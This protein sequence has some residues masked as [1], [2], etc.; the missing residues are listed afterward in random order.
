MTLTSERPRHLAQFAG[1]FLA[2]R[3]DLDHLTIVRRRRQAT[4]EQGFHP[5]GLG[6][7]R[8][9]DPGDVLGHVDAA[10][11]DAV[12]MDQLAV[13]E[14]RERRGPAAHVDQGRA[15]RGLV[16][17]QAAERRGVGRN[18]LVGDFQVTAVDA[19]GQVAQRPAR[20]R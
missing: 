19:G 6:E 14:D 7:R 1:T 11:G 18:D 15:Q 8:R 9:Q 10:D 2:H 4:S 20:R 12:G 5:L 17:D 13:E 16:V 3:R